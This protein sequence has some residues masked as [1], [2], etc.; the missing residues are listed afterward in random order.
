MGLRNLPIQ[1]KTVEVAEGVTFT[2]RGFSPNDA[3]TLYHRHAGILSTMFDD[4]VSQQKKIRGKP[5]KS[6]NVDVKELGVG[7]V[8]G[9]PRLMAEVIAIASGSV[10]PNL[11]ERDAEKLASQSSRLTCSPR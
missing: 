6:P 2:V 7:L 5:A 9:A 4:F 11:L 1:H 3:L 10:V 8:N